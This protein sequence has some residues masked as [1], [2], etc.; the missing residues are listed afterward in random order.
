[1]VLLM[2]ISRY[3]L[4][5]LFITSMLMLSGCNGEPVFTEMST[6]RLKI[7]IKGTLE[8][9]S[10]AIDNF[11]FTAGAGVTA[12]YVDSGSTNSVDDQTTITNDKFP[13]KFMFDISEIKLDGKPIGNYRQVLSVPLV[14]TEPF[15][16]GTG[17][18]LKNDDPGNGSYSSVQLYIRKM[19]FDNANIYT[20]EG[21]SW[22]TTPELAEVIFHEDEVYGFNFNNLQVNSYWDSL[23]DNSSDVLRIYPLYIPVIGGMNYDRS[24]D[25]TVLE[26]R[27]VIKNFIK[28]YE[29]DYYDDGIFKVCH[30]YGLSD[31]LRDVRADERDMGRNIIAVARAY[32]P[33]KTGTIT[34]TDAS[35]AN[36]YVM[37]IPDTNEELYSIT[38]A[39]N[40]LRTNTVGSGATYNC[41]FPVAPV[42]S[43]AHIESVL[44]YFCNY[45]AYKTAWNT[46]ASSCANITNYE[47]E[48]EAY[49]GSVENFRIAPY[50]TVADG[51]GN[52][53]FNNVQP[54]TYYIYYHTAPS[55]NRELFV[56]SWTSVNSEAPVTVP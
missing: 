3:I 7:V 23:L 31:W 14:D 50:L 16:D 37:A 55:T 26:I 2:N 41:D 18:V 20:F 46:V 8:S 12:G 35:A 5:L 29:Y 32:V 33:G 48:W 54:G 34:R 17:I 11:D 45:E 49:E 10:S 19:I 36:C 15:F 40:T 44:D 52:Y 24:N 39:G 9:E 1:M 21:S 47:N 22:N 6:N 4:S 53:T 43:G 38:S 28:M 25:E 51:S 27:I 42:Y 30:F 13:T 56:G